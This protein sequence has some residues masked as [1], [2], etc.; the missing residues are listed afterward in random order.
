MPQEDA[1]LHIIAEI[2]SIFVA[3]PAL[4]YIGTKQKNGEYVYFRYILILIGILTLVV[5][6]YLLLQYKKWENE[7]CGCEY[8]DPKSEE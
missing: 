1:K 5:D 6:G 2:L 3:A 7:G 8:K 4:I